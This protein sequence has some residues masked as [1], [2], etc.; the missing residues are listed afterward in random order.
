VKPF[1]GWRE[2]AKK[3]LC[4]NRRFQAMLLQQQLL[5]Q[6]ATP[7]ATASLQPVAQTH[8]RSDVD[9][10]SLAL[11][12]RVLAPVVRDLSVAAC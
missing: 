4:P 7:T 9:F 2:I 6:E 8:H 1:R 11:S 3:V 12:D 5:L 10:V